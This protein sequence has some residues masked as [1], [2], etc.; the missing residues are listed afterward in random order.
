MAVRRHALIQA[1]RRTLQTIEEREKLSSGDPT[2][3]ELKRSI[4]QSLAELEG[5]EEMREAVDGG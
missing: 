5:R 2:L 3:A 1:L 4:V